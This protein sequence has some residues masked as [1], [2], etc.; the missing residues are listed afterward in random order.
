MK[1]MN[2]FLRGYAFR[3]A[4]TMCRYSLTP[5]L[6]ISLLAYTHSSVES[7]NQT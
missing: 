7:V 2:G 5:K 4:R 6:L 3:I 1:G